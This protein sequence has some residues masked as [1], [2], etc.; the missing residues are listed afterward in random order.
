MNNTDLERLAK[1]AEATVFLANRV[2]RDALSRFAD[3][4]VASEGEQ[5]R[6]VIL[7]RDHELRRDLD[8]A[9]RA[10]DRGE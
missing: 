6:K 4:V 3:V 1:Q 7:Q 9:S 10:P 8:I 2:Y 5:W